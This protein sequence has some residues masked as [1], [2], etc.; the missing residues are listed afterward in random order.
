MLASLLFAA[1]LTLGLRAERSSF[2]AVEQKVSRPVVLVVMAG[3]SIIRLPVA[4]ARYREGGV[5]KVLLT[6]DGV[7]GRWSKEHQRNLYQVEWAARRLV[8]F[9]VPESAIVNL[10]FSKSG[11]IHDV[12]AV[13]RYVEDRG[14]ERL[15]VVTSDYHTR[16]TLWTFQRA[17]KDSSVQVGIFGAEGAIQHESTIWQELAEYRTLIVEF[18]KYIYYRVRY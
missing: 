6:N 15:L 11:T 4:A 18:G 16:R 3:D 8:E 13:L 17:F 10:P 14:I 1:G 2:L 12:R 7:L 5:E 9:G